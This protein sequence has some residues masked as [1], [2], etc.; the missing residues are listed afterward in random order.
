MGMIRAFPGAHPA[1]IFAELDV[2]TVN[3]DDLS[4]LIPLARDMG[5]LPIGALREKPPVGGWKI[6]S[7]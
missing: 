6:W 5:S 1:G 4:T 7:G 2:Q 3:P